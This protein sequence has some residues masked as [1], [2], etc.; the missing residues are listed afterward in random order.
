MQIDRAQSIESGRRATTR[1]AVATDLTGTDLFDASELRDEHSAF[2]EPLSAVK[3]LQFELTPLTTDSINKPAHTR[4]RRPRVD[5][6]RMER[7]PSVDQFLGDPVGRWVIASS[8]SVV[9]CAAPDLA[10]CVTWGRPTREETEVVLRTFDGVFHPALASR[11]D[12]ILNGRDIE[13]IDPDALRLLLDW[14]VARKARLASRVR[15]QFGV[16]A[17]GLVGV[18]LAGILPVLGEHHE[19]RVVRDAREAFRALS[20]AGDALCDEVEGIVATA[21]GAPRELRELRELLRSRATEAT[22]EVAARAL[23]LSER[24]LQRILKDHGT[25]F[26]SELR[27]A[28][29]AVAYERLVQ[30]DEKVIAV[31][32]RVGLSE[33]ALTQ[34][35]REK[36]GVTPAELRKRSR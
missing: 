6:S 26:T 25:T 35:V 16:I 7:S 12:V 31:A 27:D 36:T 18:T 22:L 13:G 4:A 11:V 30:S 2:R 1:A 21:R 3:K 28:R 17:D 19:F 15:L 14:L 34:L 8:S 33:N 32:A 20:P 29:F 24:T 5:C 9:F 23:A 10:G